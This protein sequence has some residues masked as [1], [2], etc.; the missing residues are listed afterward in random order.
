[1]AVHQFIGSP[2]EPYFRA[3]EAVCQPLGGRPHW[4]KLHYRTA[5]DLRPVYPKFDEFV[6]VRDRLDP[7]RVFANDFLN[8]VL[9]E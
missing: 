3:V 9:G 5:E 1:V 8:R 6:A 2:Y 7:G 4:G